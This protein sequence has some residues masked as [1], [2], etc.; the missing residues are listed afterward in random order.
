MT[1]YTIIFLLATLYWVGFC[2]F[3]YSGKDCSWSVQT[4]FQIFDKDSVESKICPEN[5]DC[6]A[7]KDIKD[8]VLFLDINNTTS[9]VVY[10]KWTEGNS[11]EDSCIQIHLYTHDS[12][13]VITLQ[14]LTED[15]Q[16]SEENVTVVQSLRW[17]DIELNYKTP[18]KR[19]RLSLETKS[20]ET[21]GFLIISNFTV[22]LDCSK[23]SETKSCSS[24]D[25]F[26]CDDSTCI[27][28][29]KV[30]DLN[31]DCATGKDEQICGSLPELARCTF[32]NGT[33]GWRQGRH[34]D[35]F[36]WNLNSG[37]KPPLGTGPSVDHTTGS[38]DGHYIY[39][40]SGTPSGYFEPALLQSPIMP[41]IEEKFKDACKLRFF[42]HM[43]G[44]DVNK[45]DVRLFDVCDRNKTSIW[46]KAGQ[47]GDEWHFV[48]ILISGIS[49][50]YLVSIEG[51]G[52]HSN[53]GD[54]AIDDISFSPECFGISHDKKDFLSVSCYE[55]T[56]TVPQFR[57]NPNFFCS[58]NQ[59][60]NNKTCAGTEQLLCENAT[61]LQWSEVCNSQNNCLNERDEQICDS[62]L[63][64]ARCTFEAGTCGWRERTHTEGFSWTLHQ[65]PTATRGTGP[66][67]DHTLG[68]DQGY[69]MYIDGGKG[70]AHEHATLQGLIMPVVNETFQDKC[71]LRF[72]YH[73]RGN[74]VTQLSIGV[75]DACTESKSH[76]WSKQSTQGD[77][78]IYDEISLAGINSRYL[79]EIDAF[80][81][82]LEHGDIAIDDISY[83]PECF[84]I[85]QDENGCIATSG[86]SRPLTI[87]EFR[88][89]SDAYCNNAHDILST[90]SS[91]IYTVEQEE[92]I[93]A[94]YI[95]VITLAAVVVAII[96]G[97][98]LLCL[99]MRRRKDNPVQTA[100]L[101]MV[102]TVSD[103]NTPPVQS[104]TID[105][106]LRCAVT[107]LNPNYDFIIAKYPEQ[108]LREIPRNKLKLLRLLG[109]GAFG[110]VYEGRLKNLCANVSEL[111]VAVKTLPA[112][113]TK[114]A[115]TDFLM[116]AVI[117][118]K[119]M[120]KNVVK[121]LGVCFEE[122]PRYIILE[123]LDG[124]DLRTFL[125]DSRTKGDQKCT[126]T[127]EELLK[128]ALD[129]ANGCRHLEEKH[130]VHR[131]IAARNC[132]LTSRGPERIAKIADFG[133]SRDIYSAD[134]Y[135][136]DGKAMLPVKWMPPEAF[137]DGVFTTKTDTWA[138]GVLLWEIFTLGY[139]PYPGQTNSD[140]M[141]FV[142]SGGRLDPPEKCP[143]R[144]SKIMIMCWNSVADI[145]PSFGEIIDLLDMCLQD[146]EVLNTD[147][148]VCQF[149]LTEC[150]KDASTLAKTPST[151]EEPNDK[152]SDSQYGGASGTAA[153]FKGHFESQSREP[154]LLSSPDI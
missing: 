111:P 109:Q 50:R 65:G 5:S 139:M 107:E 100:R 7:V 58:T 101:E 140:V 28:W 51:Y 57:K 116:E 117:I 84:G 81:A 31:K 88:N 80:G 124:G 78:W 73:M 102:S 40:D 34:F 148:S 98:T 41:A 138:F 4:G 146:E 149:P 119:F 85:S 87:Q 152:S 59:A 17:Q 126:L 68:T 129:I 47:Q 36:N 9:G 32:E 60:K 106:Q 43:F 1:I 38:E 74:D 48:E 91:P 55:K 75:I 23:G 144:L 63:E 21:S 151:A 135:R 104:S 136:K 3:C 147:V 56:M 141:H 114:Q 72:F 11:K 105:M 123:L 143:A 121:C 95:V 46:S 131:D 19:F 42:Y 137:L 86:Y 13:T 69:F 18:T 99:A 45:L 66:E 142:A 92:K 30:C 134:Y 145:R 153:E 25:E 35:E 62:L 15:G 113:S 108:Q 82:M 6:D 61:C 71:K 93:G 53:N 39:I 89:N 120:H 16:I 112:L 130:F 103:D 27:P 110:E 96:M 22:H 29:Q 122:H 133:M 52:G 26:M 115:E 150:F 94:A 10:S 8:K 44:K 77:D 118:S 14:V 125:R 154:L 70:D 37:P 79:V 49:S 24:Q 97:S 132:L 90:I 64:H 128:L 127:M 83:S 2:E 20:Q 33:C 54:I 67:V 12:T 76:I